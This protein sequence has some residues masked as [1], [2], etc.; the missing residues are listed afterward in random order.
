M[1]SFHVIHGFLKCLPDSGPLTPKLGSHKATEMN[2]VDFF[3]KWAICFYVVKLHLRYCTVPQE[4]NGKMVYR[5]IRL[6]YFL[7]YGFLFLLKVN[8][9][10]FFITWMFLLWRKKIAC[11]FCCISSCG[12]TLCNICSGPACFIQAF[13]SFI[14]L[15]TTFFFFLPPG[16]LSSPVPD[17]AGF[18][19]GNTVK[20][21]AWQITQWGKATVWTLLRVSSPGLTGA[22]NP[23]GTNSF[24]TVCMTG[25]II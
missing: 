2:P 6:F 4:R 1:F 16:L 19:S 25:R 7:Y 9:F 15:K 21:C 18:K 20:G 8:Y 5:Y 24:N 10:C 22:G 12:A 23:T 3:L 14:Y 11:C 13:D 17:S